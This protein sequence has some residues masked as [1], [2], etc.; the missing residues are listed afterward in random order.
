MAKARSFFEELRTAQARKNSLLCVGLDPD[1]KKIAQWASSTDTVRNRHV[2]Q[3]LL[4]ETMILEEFITTKG[5]AAFLEVVVRNTAR[6]A[7]VFKPNYAYF[8][9]YGMEEELEALIGYV[10][11][12][13]RTPVIL[14]AKRG[15][16]GNTAEAY[17]REAFDRYGADALTVNPY[18]GSDTLEP[19]LEHRDKGIIVLCRTSNKGAAQYQNLKLENGLRLYEQVA[20]DMA[21]LN[22]KYGGDR[23]GLVVG[24]TY[25][26]ELARVRQLVGGDVEL[27]IPG[28]GAQ[29]GDVEATVKAGRNAGAAG[30][31]INSSRAII[32]AQDQRGAAMEARDQINSHL[33]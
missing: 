21:E 28:I 1:V 15:D 10:R 13:Y 31:I 6:F 7:S 23:I 11:R 8:A 3:L 17:A 30:M 22:A 12:Y 18:M 33:S 5:I 16:I 14:D 9:Q 29:G 32:Y 27:L 20:V 19:Y 25:P 24:A 2:R 4:N 26:E